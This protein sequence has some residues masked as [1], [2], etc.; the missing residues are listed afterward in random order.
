MAHTHAPTVCGPIHSP[1]HHKT[2]E[3]LLPKPNRF[4]A[5]DF[6]LFETV[7]QGDPTRR[8]WQFA[9]RLRNTAGEELVVPLETSVAAPHR[10]PDFAEELFFV[11]KMKLK[12]EITGTCGREPT[13]Y[14]GS[15]VRSS[16]RDGVTHNV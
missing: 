13:D 6:W 7:T 15:C 16:A 1:W 14:R 4:D 9:Q 12:A 8:A 10:E 5:K 2:S 11:E 3:K